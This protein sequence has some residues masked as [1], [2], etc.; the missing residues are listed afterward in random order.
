MITVTPDI[1][2]H[3]DELQFSAVKASGPG[4]QHVNTTNSAVQLKFD[5]ANS[6]AIRPAVL[7]RLRAIAGRRMTAKG[8]I[9]LQADTER[10][11]HR[12]RAIAQERLIKM[13]I[14]ASKRPKRRVKTRPTKGSVTR[15]LDSKTRTGA[16]KKSRGHIRNTD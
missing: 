13:I 6:P 7:L 4:G 3:V 8:V 14:T 16:L 1:M 9:I 5:A 2:L 11:Q 12:N 10:S 15:R